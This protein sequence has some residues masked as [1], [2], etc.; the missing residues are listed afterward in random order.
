MWTIKR[1]E[2]RHSMPR[3]SGNKTYYN[4]GE[5]QALLDV[6]HVTFAALKRHH[7][8]EGIKIQGWGPSIWYQLDDLVKIQKARFGPDWQPPDLPEE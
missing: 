8:I 6:S 3:R 5:A 4:G 7:G 2:R 1:K